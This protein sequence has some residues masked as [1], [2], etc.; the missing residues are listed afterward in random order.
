ME[1]ESVK[2][3]LLVE[4]GIGKK[5]IIS[6]FTEHKFDQNTLSSLS[7]QFVFKNNWIFRLLESN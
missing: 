5:C 1:P 3:V 2:V 4:S 6:Q 7:A